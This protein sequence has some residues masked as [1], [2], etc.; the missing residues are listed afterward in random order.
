MRGIIREK[1]NPSSQ[2]HLYGRETYDRLMQDV[3]YFKTKP[4][5]SDTG[6]KITCVTFYILKTENHHAES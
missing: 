3:K 1:Q 4:F 6:D 2:R 5:E